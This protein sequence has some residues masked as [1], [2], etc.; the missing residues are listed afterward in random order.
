MNYNRTS[1]C[2]ADTRVIIADT[3]P[4]SSE[5]TRNALYDLGIRKFTVTKT[6]ADTRKKLSKGRFDVLILHAFL[7]DE[8]TTP[9][10]FDVR[11]QKLGEDPFIPI[12]ALT[13]EPTI[14]VVQGLISAG[15]DQM[16]TLPVSA[17][18]ID[19]ALGNLIKRRKPFVVTSDYIGPDRRK[20]PRPDVQQV[21]RIEVPN[22]LRQSVTGDDGGV[23]PT[24]IQQI[25]HDQLAERYANRIVYTISKIAGLISERDQ[26]TM[27]T[28]LADLQ[29]FA[30]KIT[31]HIPDTSYCHHSTLCETLLEVVERNQYGKSPEI[32]EL[33][34]MQQLALSIQVGFNRNDTST[35]D[36][37]L[38]VTSTMTDFAAA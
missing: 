36:S 27:E 20:D 16:L 37:A 9:I 30:T 10:V 6:V 33:T 24:A 13:W 29:V 4:A 32:A 12:I 23:S 26:G 7:M 21:A 22:A 34:I 11:H 3:M 31:E 14:E 28:W 19:E 2:F 15:I 35:V 17:N 25:V 38:D 8:F 18:K 5:A 1:F